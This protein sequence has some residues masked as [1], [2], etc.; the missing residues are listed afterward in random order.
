MARGPVLLRAQR[1]R[2]RVRKVQRE[3]QVTDAEKIEQIKVWI[4]EWANND[5]KGGGAAMDILTEIM[6]LLE[7]DPY[8]DDKEPY[9]GPINQPCSACS[10]GDWKMEFHDH[11]YV[12]MKHR[13]ATPAR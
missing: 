13:V 10:A 9:K 3:V 8:A 6:H 2:W 7:F 5:N 4:G 11:D 1:T 12:D